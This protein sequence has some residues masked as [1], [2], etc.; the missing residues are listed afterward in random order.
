MSL[1]VFVWRLVQQMSLETTP[2]D[3]VNSVSVN[4]FLALLQLY[5]V[6]LL[7]C[8]F[9]KHPYKAMIYKAREHVI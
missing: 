8:A 4:S 1:V 2:L 9:N 6:R 5:I 7:T 3:G